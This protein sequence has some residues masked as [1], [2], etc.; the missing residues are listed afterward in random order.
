[1]AVPKLYGS[2]QNR[3][4]RPLWMA[5]ELGIK[6]DF[7]NIPSRPG[8]GLYPDGPADA[9]AEF[10]RTL[11]PNSKV[12]VLVD[13][14]L[15]LWESMAINLYLVKKHGGPLAP[16]N[17]QEDALM[18]QWSFW[19]MT[20]VEKDALQLVFSTLRKTDGTSYAENLKRPMSALEKVLADKE[21]LVGGRFTAADLNVA[22]V[23]MWAQA[24]RFDFSLYPKVGKWLGGCLARP[25]LKAAQ[26]KL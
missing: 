16:K 25:A 13:G 21:Y 9:K 18:S 5:R 20:E 17:A 23:L 2:Q 1:M 19:V 22:S 8:E 26:A 11:N 7:E 12:P 10:E 24:A 3:A 14:D 6:I 15:I 4:L